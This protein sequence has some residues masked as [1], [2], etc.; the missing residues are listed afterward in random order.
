QQ[1]ARLVGRQASYAL[2]LALALREQLLAACGGGFGSLLQLH[3]R[4]LALAQIALELVGGGETIG[5]RA[6]PIGERRLEAD[7]LLLALAGLFLGVGD[8]GVRLLACFELGFLLDRLGLALGL[9]TELPRVF[10]G[11]ADGF[12][13]DPFAAGN[14]VRDRGDR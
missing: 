3:K 4:G 5:E 9:G 13:G 11:A 7:D 6:R 12:G 8:Q 1:V 10:F 2:Q 14:P